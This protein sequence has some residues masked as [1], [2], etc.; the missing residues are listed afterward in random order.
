[1][2]SQI[3][4]RNFRSIASADIDGNWI[5]TFVGANDA[6]KSNILRALN[7]FFN[8]ETN[9]GERFDFARDFNQFAAAR[10]RRAAQI[11]IR[12]TFLLPSG[13]RR[14]GYPDFI[15][16]KKVWR[17]E[18]EVARMQ[19]RAFVTG[20]PFPPRSKIPVLLDRVRFTY[21]PAIKDKAFFADL[22][23]RLY[24]VLSSVAEK[25]L[26]DSAG[27]FQAQL[28]DQ[29]NDLLVSI[30][31]T[32]GADASMR[33]PDDLRSIFESLEINSGDV[34]L[35]RRGDGIKIRHIPMILRFIAEK[36]DEL[37]NRGGVRYTH[38]WGFEEPEN[39]VEM[40]AAFQMAGELYQQIAGSEHFQLFLTTHS[41]VFYRLDQQSK[42]AADWV[43][44][45][46][47]EKQGAESRLTTKSTKE[48]DASMG[49]MPLLAPHVAQAKQ[50]FDAVQAELRAVKD[51]AEQKVPTLFVEGASDQQVLRKAWEIFSGRPAGAVHICVGGH[52]AYGGAT[53][54]H[55][56]ALAWLLNMRHRK[57][58]VQAAALFDADSS[59]TASRRAL[60]DDIKRMNLGNPAFRILSLDT[61]PRLQDLS[62]KGF[63]LPIDLEAYYTDALWAHAEGQNDWLELAADVERRLSA[64]MVRELVSK[65]TNPIDGLS[66]AD[67]LRLQYGFSDRGKERASKR[68]AALS[69]AEAQRELAAFKPLI[70]ALV[71]HLQV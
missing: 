63:R 22:Q 61:P 31:D 40:S 54:L 9:P 48:V 42:E 50:K 10:N 45:H 36:R 47:V 38:I 53:A 29:L 3:S 27:A 25:P 4:I 14:E 20:E 28:G 58:R 56:R 39:N 21:V 1:M 16:W 35:S 70:E 23:G 6:G 52:G 46:F 5:T 51:L 55:S 33:L 17:E 8:G 13:Y 7:L 12:I 71:L 18:G 60:A 64:K 65:G 11:E 2:I 57:T 30:K 32:F 44:T 24:D 69:G 59:G 62:K 49:L 43:T 26:K 67:K 15:E 68:I 34:P 19:T 66:P 37:L 41:P